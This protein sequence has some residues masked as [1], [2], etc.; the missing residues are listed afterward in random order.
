MGFGNTAQSGCLPSATALPNRPPAMMSKPGSPVPVIE[1]EPNMRSFL[2]SGFEIHGFS[3][4]EAEN[5]ADGLKIAAFNLPNLVIL[6]LGLPDLH[7]SEVLERL[8]SWSDVPV[9]VLSAE[10]N[11]DEM[12]RLL[13]SGADDYVVNHSA[14]PGFSPAVMPCCAAISG[15]RPRAR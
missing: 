3:V 12:V 8:R 1:G 14:W 2:R 11:E 15:V 4:A 5:A 13:R 10:S 6:D 7:G 9:I